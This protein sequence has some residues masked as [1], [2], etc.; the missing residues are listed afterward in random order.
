MA[1]ELLYFMTRCGHYICDSRY[2]VSS[3]SG[4]GLD[5][6]R[7]NFL[8]IYVIYGTL[9]LETAGRAYLVRGGQVALIDCRAAHEYKAPESIEF[10]WLHFDGVNSHQIVNQ[11]LLR[12]GRPVFSVPSEGD[13]L[14]QLKKLLAFRENGRGLPEIEHSLI[15]YR[16]LCNL[17]LAPQESIESGGDQSL[18]DQALRY[19]ESQQFKDISVHT[20]AQAVHLSDSH[21]SRTYKKQTGYSPKEY[22]ILKRIG[23]AKYLL[24][25]TN[26]SVREIAEV[27]GYQSDVHFIHSFEGKVGVS[28][29]SFR[30]NPI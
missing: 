22:I 10:Y 7:R 11:I 26:L 9:T 5:A 30:H 8:L 3:S 1:R 14:P 24:T 19:I 17:L 23:Q 27:T 2:A 25:T 6:N 21:F 13:L 12:K 28:P 18:I 4:I 16:I 20:V 29:T 15:I